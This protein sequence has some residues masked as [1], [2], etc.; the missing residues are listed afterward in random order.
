MFLI[1][2]ARH[3]NSERSLKI[4]GKVSVFV[5]FWIKVRV[6]KMSVWRSTKKGTKWRIKK[7]NAEDFRTR[8]RRG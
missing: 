6:S 2:P 7:D 4:R 5:S 1:Y 8:E 3:S